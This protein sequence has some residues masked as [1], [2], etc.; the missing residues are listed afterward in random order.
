[1][2]IIP[3]NAN[4]IRNV[5]VGRLKDMKDMKDFQPDITDRLVRLGRLGCGAGALV[6]RRNPF[7]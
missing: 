2:F 3:D 6:R 1:M 7:R 5:E 4:S